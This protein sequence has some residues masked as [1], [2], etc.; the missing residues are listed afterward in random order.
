MADGIYALAG[1]GEAG[2]KRALTNLQDELIRDMKLMGATSIADLGRITCAS[3]K[4]LASARLKRSSM[5][6]GL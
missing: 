6:S 2:V 3:A 4:L 1:A 5:K